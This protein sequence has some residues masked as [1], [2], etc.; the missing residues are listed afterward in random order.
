MRLCRLCEMFLQYAL[1]DLYSCFITNINI[2]LLL[3][4]QLIFIA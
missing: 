2:I 3:A 4:K 1:N